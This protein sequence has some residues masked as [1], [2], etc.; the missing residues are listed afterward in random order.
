MGLLLW[1]ALD[2]THA[3]EMHFSLLTF[4]LDANYI[5]NKYPSIPVHTLFDCHPERGV[6]AMAFSRD[7]K[8]L[9]TLGAEE[10]QVSMTA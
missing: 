4:A 8:H 3:V 5:Y 2:S 9:V 6:T 7:A 1:V 10:V